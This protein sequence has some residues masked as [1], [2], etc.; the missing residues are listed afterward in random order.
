MELRL[1]Y[2]TPKA[3]D[4]MELIDRHME[5]MRD[6]SIGDMAYAMLEVLF[7]IL[8]EDDNDFG[9]F[10]SFQSEETPPIGDILFQGDPLA[11]RKLVENYSAFDGPIDGYL[12]RLD[13]FNAFWATI[14]Q[15]V[16]MG[17]PFVSFD[18]AK[19]HIENNIMSMFNGLNRAGL[20]F[21]LRYGE[22]DVDSETIFVTD[23]LGDHLN[24]TNFNF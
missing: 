24:N 10:V 16:L 23:S 2:E 14:A 4:F 18:A 20:E 1:G 9:Y 8:V 22:K 19:N 13:T 3:K 12:T 11:F 21:T 15:Q 17:I 6:K 5:T 7:N